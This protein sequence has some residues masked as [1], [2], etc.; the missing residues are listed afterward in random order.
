M[1]L[2]PTPCLELF[3]KAAMRWPGEPA[4]VSDQRRL[5]FA[6][7]DAAANRLAHLLI[8]RG[9]GP[10]RIVA[11][12][13][14]RSVEIVIAQLAVLKAGAAFLPVDPDYPAERIDLMLSD[15]APVLVVTMAGEAAGRGPVLL[16]DAADTAASLD[17]QPSTGP[18]DADRLAPL[19]PAHPAYVIYTSGSTGR[20]KGVVVPHAGLGNFSAAQIEHF[21]VRPGDRV[22][23]FSSP[24]FDASVLELFL[25]LPA[26]AALVVPPPGPLVGR[27]L[28]DVL[29]AGRVTHAL[30]PPVALAT[31]PPVELPDFRTLVVGGDA[32]PAELV[33]RWAPGRR[34]INAYGPTEATVVGTWSGPLSAGGGRP[35]IGRP[36]P[37]ARAHVL[38]GELRPAATGELYLAGA[39]VTRGYLARP[40][41]TAERFVADPAGPPGSRMY[42][43]GDVVRRR[44]DGQLDF[45]GRADHQVKIR[46]YR[47][48]PGE[49]EAVLRRHPGVEDVVV[50]GRSEAGGP[51]R[52][53]AYLVVAEGATGPGHGELR[54]LV[55]GSLPDHMIPSAF[56]P[57]AAFPLSPNGKLDRAALPP[58]GPAA[59]APA[60][61][62]PGG[63]TVAPRTERERLIAG[64]WAEVLGLA[65]VGVHDDFFCLGGDSILA[66]MV[67]ARVRDAVGAELSPLALF[68]GR[69]VAR[70]AEL[71]PPDQATGFR[72]GVARNRSARDGRIQPV[73]PGQTVPLSPAQQRMWVLDGLA[74]GGGRTGCNTGVGLRLRGPLDLPALRSALAG[75]ARRHEAL[76]TTFDAGGS[77]DQVRQTVAE[78]AEIPLRFVDLSPLPVPRQDGAVREL[79]AGEL[80]LPFDLRRGPLTRVVLLRLGAREHVLMLSQHHIVTDGWSVRLLVAELGE[81]YAAALRGTPARLPELPELPIRYADYAAWHRRRLDSAD[82]SADLDYWAR[83]LAGA[84]PVEL[85][86][87]RAGQ[88]AARRRPGA[89]PGA[90]HR[91]ALPAD[92]VARLS[93]VG[94]AHGATLFM[95]LTAAVTVLLAGY[96]GQRD[97]AVGTVSSGR[98]RTEL[99]G[100]AGFFVNTLVL[101]SR[102]DPARPFSAFLAQVRQ[103]VLEAFAHGAVPFDRLVA[104]LRQARDPGWA[105]LARVVVALHQELVQPAR[106]GGLAFEEHD[107]PRT[108]AR[109][110]LVVEF[111]PRAGSLIQT[112]EYRTDLFEAGTIERLGAHLEA[113][114][115]AIVAE[116][117]RVLSELPLP[118]DGLRAATGAVDSDG[119]PGGT[120]QNG[121]PGGTGKDGQPGGTGQVG[122][123]AGDA[124]PYLAPRTPVEATLAAVF[125][126]VLGL[127]MVGVRDNFFELGGDSILSIQV[128]TGARAAG[129][130]LS[131]GDVFAYQSV[132]EL[133][134]HV[135]P[136]GPDLGEPAYSPAPEVAGEVPLTP[137]QRWFFER[138]PRPE[139]FD[140]SLEVAL[141][142][143]RAELD[144]AALKAAVDALVEHHDAL[145]LRFEPSAGGG[146]RQ[147]VDDLVSGKG[148]SGALRHSQARRAVRLTAHHL[149][150]DGVSW[151]ILAEDLATAYRQ[152]RRG[153]PIRL[154][155]RTTPFAQWARRLAEHA[156]GGGF[157][158]E[159]EHWAATAAAGATAARIPVD[160]DGQNTYASERTVTVEL[161]RATTAALLR[162]VPRRYRTRVNDALLTALGLALRGWTGHGPVLLDVEGHGREELFGGVDLS[163]T[164]GWFTSVFPVVLE[165][166]GGEH[167]EDHGGGAGAALKAVKERLRAVPRRGIGYGALRH[168]TTAGAPPCAPQVSVN[169]LGRFGGEH[170]DLTLDADP[171]AERP[172]LLDVV[173]RVDAGSLRLTWHYSQ[174]VH[175]ER[176]VARLAEAT[177]AALRGIVEHCKQPGAG[178]CTPSDFPLADLDQA[179]VDRLAGDGRNIADIYPLTPMQAGMVFHGLAGGG[180]RERERNREPDREPGRE[181]EQSAYFQQASFVLDGVPDSRRLAQ[182]WQQVVDRT[183]ILRSAVAWEGVPEPLQVVHRAAAVPVTYLDWHGVPDGERR[184]RLA[185]LLARDR[186]AP[187]DLTRP[188]L[189]RLALAR[190]SATEVQVLWTFHHV[191][192]DGWSVFH[193]LSDVFAGH[194]GAA[195][196]PDRPP[197]RD[198]VRWLRERTEADGGADGRSDPSGPSQ[199]APGATERHWRAVLGDLRAPTPLPYDRPPAG[200]H[201]SRSVAQCTVRLPAGDSARLYE[202]ARRHRLTPSAVVQGAWA[203]LLSRHSGQRDVCFG[204]T[205]SGRPAELAGVDAMTGMFINTLPVRVDTGGPAARAG[206]VAWLRELQAAQARSRRHEHAPLTRLHAW[207]GLPGG[208]DLFD[209]VVVF[210]NY[211]ID[212]EAAAAHGLRLRELTAVETTNFAL[213]ATVYPGQRLTVRLGYEPRLFDEATVRRLGE[214][215]R[216]LLTA[217][218]ADPER[219]VPELPMLGQRERRRALIDWN[220]TAHPVPPATLPELVAAQAR[221]TPEAPAVIVDGAVLPYR[222]LDLRANRLANRLVAAGAGPE[223]VVAVALPRSAELVVT[224]LA[225]LKAGAAYL[226]LDPELPARRVELMIA[227]AAPVLVI[228]EPLPAGTFPDTDPGTSTST[229]TGAGGPLRPANPAYV[230]YTSGS[231]GRPKGVVVPHGGIVNRLLWT[232]HEYRLRPDDRVLHKTPTGFDVSVWELFWPLV[233]GAAMVV[234]RPGGHQ[235]P[236]YLAGLIA[237]ESVTTVHFVPS[238]LRAYL[239][240]PAAAATAGRTALRRVLSSGEA[241]TADLVRGVR[242]V[243]GVELHNLYGPTEASVDVTSWRCDPDAGTVPIG[244]PVWNTALYVLDAALRPVP[245]GVPGELYLA[246]AQLARGYLNRP[247]LTAD[248]FVANPFGAAGTRMYRSGDVARWRADG[249]V[250][251]LGRTDRQVKIRGVRVELG[252]I[253]AVLGRHAEVAVEVHG[254]RLV[255]YVAPAGG[256]NG[257]NGQ[258]DQG[259]QSDQGGGDPDVGLLR[260]VAA[261]NLPGYLVPSAF[262]RLDRLPLTP[263]GKLDRRALPPPDWGESAA[264]GYVAPRTETEEA[265]ARI[266]A[267][268]LGLD[269]VGVLDSFYDLGGDS[270]RSLHI[271]S[272]TRAA[273]DIDIGPRDVLAA[274]TVARLADL[275]EELVIGE[276][277]RLADVPGELATERQGRARA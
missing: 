103:T 189:M 267:D 257:Q 107:L 262:V 148:R 12:A 9:A 252:E 193:V 11:L 150:V 34:M 96:R 158:G 192:L 1:P 43:T 161:D 95:V 191:L 77:P 79:L 274:G 64:I 258:N 237:A 230:I 20:P 268:V 22:L 172:H 247:G 187:F 47:I 162:E 199:D 139:R 21:A 140:Q 15:A 224:L 124:V 63:A 70:L 146:W 222:E 196:L 129:L 110:D 232:Q 39:G 50:V 6:E 93:Q 251:Y 24:S 2:P 102:L 71:L 138:H 248:R 263:S 275:V 136:A 259:D 18:A 181:P 240:E 59:P 195:E 83:T 123:V 180:E 48:E 84:R 215:L 229:G 188:P 160:G 36:I 66:A 128:V 261:A 114:L 218:P 10:E 183:P 126:E 56:V 4:V 213:S 92:L 16:L 155:P 244:R 88:P 214:H 277:E 276:L 208:T 137:I 204:A 74:D 30:I 164:V 227:D 197:F 235:D 62:G 19:R 212:T 68:D 23:Q 42:R 255:A 104:H 223:K 133:A 49:I 75:L 228:T 238:M 185:E 231:T 13:L 270:I 157:D 239:R 201:A 38:D 117:D 219:P 134:P 253:E 264:G 242:D 31:M 173:G 256:Q 241:L 81:L 67:L 202:F 44:E 207:S 141:D 80:D 17:R 72:D 174:N 205:V 116:P 151:R 178:G 127:P 225:V 217:I 170:G 130:A 85:P 106:H 159:R 179:T 149:R 58:P 3:E 28:A 250:E 165:L 156:A 86:I 91:R 153:E 99:E 176:T 234:A 98:D 163:R 40:G 78:H 210:E 41:L 108:S 194:T 266:W 145:R 101:R 233:T 254:E 125:A 147:H 211:P 26:G 177:I 216:A 198:Y 100:L 51:K 186:A 175:H 109:F 112:I 245:P 52:L 35:P 200:R 121:Q 90:V 271:T 260:E 131:S 206:V 76:R 8:A 33:D 61:T 87:D 69:T 221:R 89:G 203:V 82:L 118:G 122:R 169:Y 236:G 273:F 166:P 142:G 73:P 144:G 29:A 132:A 57:L 53:V 143:S 120:G 272:R 27:H 54:N 37:N 249:A 45:A 209:S 243:L 265:V 220:A 152:A 32:C 14:P 269:R 135:A 184:R 226:P 46:G 115:A 105:A 113:L 5:T 55:A 119:Q 111:W 154:A 7:L 190:L 182:A 97:I 168:L 246:G 25:S 60:G 171:G 94:R 65:A 167:G